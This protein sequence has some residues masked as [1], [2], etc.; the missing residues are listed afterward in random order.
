MALKRNL[1][2]LIQKCGAL[3]LVSIS[4]VAGPNMSGKDPEPA[5]NGAKFLFIVDT[6]STMNRYEHLGR[7]TVFDLIFSGVSTQ[8]LSGD[9]FGLWTFNE[10]VSA[11]AFPMQ[12]WQADQNLELATRVGVFLKG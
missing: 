4:C 3:A 2:L 7:Q 12:V 9:T 8:M 5:Q 11:G 6:S 10:E 1:G